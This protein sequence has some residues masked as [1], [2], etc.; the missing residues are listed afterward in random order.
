DGRAEG[1]VEPAPPY[2]L[3]STD[4]EIHSPYFEISAPP[5]ARWLAQRRGARW[6][7]TEIGPAAPKEYNLDID[8]LDAWKRA[9]TDANGAQL[10]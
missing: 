6:Q 8:V 1:A 10:W 4:I 3:T 2:F 7:L 5:S 9:C